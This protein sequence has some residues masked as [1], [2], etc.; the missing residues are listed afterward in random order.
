MTFAYSRPQAPATVSAEITG[1]KANRH[2]VRMTKDGS[3]RSKLSL[4]TFGYG[5]RDKKI[6]NQ[7]CAQKI[8]DR[9]DQ[10]FGFGRFAR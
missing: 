4:V 9:F 6:R 3:G 10:S 2:R 5:H 7:Y 8:L 1:L